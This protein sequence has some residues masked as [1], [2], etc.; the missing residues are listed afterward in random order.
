MSVNKIIPKLKI[1]YEGEE[2]RKLGFKWADEIIGK[3]SKIGG[4]PDFIQS[5]D[6]PK[7]ECCNIPMTFYSQLDSLS[8]EI[9]FAD[10]GMIYI[11][12]CF[13]CYKVESFIQS[14]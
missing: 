8:D 3:R 9:C 1:A 13:D 5:E 6:T 4:V 12:V 10:C 7:C 14:G 11:F 2:S